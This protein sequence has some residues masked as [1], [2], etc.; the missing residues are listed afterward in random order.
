MKPNPRHSGMVRWCPPD[1]AIANPAAW[2]VATP[3]GQ[4]YVTRLYKG[5]GA[6]PYSGAKRKASRPQAGHEQPELRD[7]LAV[8]Y[9]GP[10]PV[11]IIPRG[12]RG[13]DA[14][15]GE[16]VSL[17]PEQRTRIGAATRLAL[18]GPSLAD[19]RTMNRRIVKA[20]ATV[21]TWS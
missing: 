8:A 10:L 4:A 6:T 17:S 2:W 21:A 11:R 9:R 19:W 15:T 3:K 13:L 16:P 1:Y 20:H 7:R 14:N 12:I 18:T 5:L